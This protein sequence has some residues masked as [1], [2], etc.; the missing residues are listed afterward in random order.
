M[1]VYVLLIFLAYTQENICY[2]GIKIDKFL[3]H[4]IKQVKMFSYLFYLV[5]ML[6]PVLAVRSMLFSK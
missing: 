6:L 3:L 1:F 2:L 5:L 4:I